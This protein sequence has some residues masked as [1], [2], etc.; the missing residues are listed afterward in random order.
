MRVHRFVLFQILFSHRL[1]QNSEQNPLQV[2]VGR[3]SC[4]WWCVSVHP[5]LLIYNPPQVSS[6]VTMFVFDIC[7]VCFC[8][9]RKFTC[10]FFFLNSVS[11]VTQLCPTLCDP[12]D[13]GSMPGFPVFLKLD[14]TYAWYHMMLVFV[15]LTSLS[16]IVSRFLHVATNGIISLHF[17]AES[18]SMCIYV[19]YLP[20]PFLCRL[21]FMW[22]PCLG[23][24]E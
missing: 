2:R 3:L 4:I 19:P 10:I 12:M 20:H 15:W 8:L 9:V 17:M 5:K 6:L 7:W 22:L 13:D 11:L 14:S 21:P 23:F 18:H 1:S 24:C 16:M